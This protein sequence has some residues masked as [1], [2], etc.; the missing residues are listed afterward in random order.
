M[1]GTIQSRVAY[2]YLAV[3]SQY[4]CYVLELPSGSV[5]GRPSCPHRCGPAGC[6]ELNEP[7]GRRGGLAAMQLWEIRGSQ[8]GQVAPPTKFDQNSIAPS[9]FPVWRRLAGQCT[10]T[11][12]QQ[13]GKWLNP[14]CRVVSICSGLTNLFA[15]NA[16]VF[17]SRGN[18]LK[19]KARSCVCC[20]V[21]PPQSCNNACPKRRMKMPLVGFFPHAHP[22][23]LLRD[24]QFL[25]LLIPTPSSSANAQRRS[26]MLPTKEG[27]L[28]LP[29]ASPRPAIG[30]L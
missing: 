11:R 6:L 10:W 2:L 28:T 5:A 14:A 8:S 7:A 29:P 24:H 4:F 23:P 27:S 1:R 21:G 13:R 20:L 26:W 3:P 19:L 30:R 9:R 17:C 18:S 15:C 22:V 16:A 25:A 12:V